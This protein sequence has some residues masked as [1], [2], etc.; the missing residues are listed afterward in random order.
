MKA[1]LK[2]HQKIGYGLYFKLQFTSNYLKKF[3]TKERTAVIARNWRELSDGEKNI[4]QR[5]S[6]SGN[7]Y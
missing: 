7:I 6:H 1:N 2:D 4:I 5:Q 3:V